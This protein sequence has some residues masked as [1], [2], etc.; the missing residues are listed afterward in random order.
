M[1]TNARIRIKDSL[2]IIVILFWVD[3]FFIHKVSAFRV[4]NRLRSG[5]FSENPL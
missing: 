5:K 3:Y 2:F 4:K 1:A